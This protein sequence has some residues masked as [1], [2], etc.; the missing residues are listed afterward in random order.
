MV[1]SNK[2]V[3]CVLVNG[4]PQNELANGTVVLP[5]NTEYVLRFR[6][7]N[8][9]K[10]VVKVSIDGE[11]V[12]DHGFIIPANDYVDI[13][14]PANKDAAFKFV[15]LDS[16]DAIDHGKNGPNPDKIKGTI[17]A[18]FYL[19]KERRVSLQ[20]AYIKQYPDWAKS[21]TVY[22]PM[23]I[24][25]QP[26]VFGVANCLR[27]SLKNNLE[28]SDSLTHLPRSMNC[29]STELCDASANQLSV[30][31]K[32][33]SFKSIVPKDGCTVEGTSTGQNFISSYIECEEAC[34]ILKIFLQG[35]P[36][37]IKVKK[38]KASLIEKENEKLRAKIAEIENKKLQEELAVLSN[39]TKKKKATK[40]KN[41]PIKKKLG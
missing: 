4:V 6:N 22:G 30:G 3:V 15:S 35:L 38:S 17:E 1:Y 5:F 41:S 34:T 40:K 20:D 26:S 9:R 2:F 8:N 11:N 37:A 32:Q 13:K 25:Y 31:Q 27:G 18:R 10:A 16:T 21:N 23:P 12:S 24:H 29:S 19:E 7:K 39:K 28:T 33:D 36:K 14:R